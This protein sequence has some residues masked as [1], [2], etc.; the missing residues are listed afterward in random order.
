MNRNLI[1]IHKYEIIEQNAFNVKLQNSY[2]QSASLKLGGV[3][4]KKR[5][6]LI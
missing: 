4:I 6:H 2:L 1:A 5:W 3:L